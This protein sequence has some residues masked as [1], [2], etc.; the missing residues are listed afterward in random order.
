MENYFLTCLL[1]TLCLGAASGCLEC[2]ESC[3][4]QHVKYETVYT[5]NRTVNLMC[6]EWF[7]LSFYRYTWYKLYPDVGFQPATNDPNVTISHGGAL[8]TYNSFTRAVGSIEFKC[9][10]QVFRG[11]EYRAKLFYVDTPK[12]VERP[13][14]NKTYQVA[15]YSYLS[16]PCNFRGERIVEAGVQFLW[17]KLKNGQSIDLPDDPNRQY[18]DISGNLHFTAVLGVDGTY[19]G[20]NVYRC[21]VESLTEP[22]TILGDYT[23]INVT[24]EP[25]VWMKPQFKYKTEVASVVKNGQ[26][27]LE[28]V[29]QDHTFPGTSYKWYG[30]NGENLTTA[31]PHKYEMFFQGRRLIVHTVQPCD[32]GWYSC[33]ASNELGTSSETVSLVVLCD[34]Y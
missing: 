12:Y 4:D 3:T 33:E 19:N 8:L 24:E 34:I 31:N 1:I 22:I 20:N 13:R 18:I 5:M 30:R 25:M 10:I 17:F 7:H 2:N 11:S 28:C 9:E 32:S 15:Q 27:I 26:A 6:R 14:Q 29:F 21:H 23:F 16:M